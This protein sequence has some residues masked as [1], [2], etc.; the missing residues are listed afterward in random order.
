MHRSS[1]STGRDKPNAFIRTTHR[2]SIVKLDPNAGFNRLNKVT[3]NWKRAINAAQLVNQLDRRHV[4]PPSEALLISVHACTND[5]SAKHAFKYAVTQRQRLFFDET[6]QD[7]NVWIHLISTKSLVWETV[8]LE[9]ANHGKQMKVLRKPGNTW[10]VFFST[11]EAH[12]VFGIQSEWLTQDEWFAIGCIPAEFV[13]KHIQLADGK[14]L[15][16]KPYKLV[17][18]SV[19]KIDMVTLDTLDIFELCSRRREDMTEEETDKEWAKACKAEEEGLVSTVRYN[20]FVYQE[21]S[22]GRQTRHGVIT[23]CVETSN[24]ESPAIEILVVTFAELLSVR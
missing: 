19:A 11:S 17:P 8:Q 12:K 5:A 1:S 6:Y 2:G 3:S 15:S 22:W 21:L 20:D 14:L 4:F 13:Q 10:P 16:G 24:L 7:P 9:G 23:T 18:T